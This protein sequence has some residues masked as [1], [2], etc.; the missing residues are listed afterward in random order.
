MHLSKRWIYGGA[1]AVA[2][3][4]LLAWA[5]APRS[6]EVEVAA[7]SQGRFE[8][9]IDEDGKTR[10]RDRYVVSAPLAG[11]L[12]RI[13]LRE[14]DPVEAGA[15]VATLQPV[16]SPMLDERTLREQQLRVDIAQAQV[17]RAAARA[18]A[19]RVQLQQARNEVRRSE[20][21]ASQGFISPNKFDNDRLGV[22]AAQKELD[23]ANED[24]HM[25]DHEVEQARAALMAVRSPTQAGAR[26]FALR[27]PIGG[28]VM[29]VVQASETVVTLGTPLLEIGD[30]RNLEVVAELLTADALRIGPGSRVLI[31]RWGGPTALEGRVR[32]IE[33]AAFT[34]VSALGVEEQRVKVLID[35]AS[36]A[37]EWAALGD[38][39]RVGV[40]IVTQSVDSAVKVPVGAVFPVAA[41]AAASGSGAADG[42]SAVFV[43]RQGRAHLVP[44]Q[45]GGRHGGEAWVSKGLTLDDVVIV[46]PSAAVKD[47]ARVSRRAV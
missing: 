2:T 5:F 23:A 13:A 33:P 9:S 29:R 7:V 12:T 21:L 22:E 39:F 25:A 36:P 46:Y 31:E 10:L 15:V 3:A 18:G 27:A 41:A 40:R 47:G 44:V 8:S 14:G 28:R 42:G 4:A 19:A 1:A 45:L 24:R 30:T 32:Q 43:F 17:Q 35:I 38:A 37:A 20:L 6:V 11:L 34:K 16:L 26:S